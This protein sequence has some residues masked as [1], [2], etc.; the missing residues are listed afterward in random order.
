MVRRESRVAVLLA[1]VVLLSACTS[2]TPSPQGSASGPID[3]RRTTL[4]IG[5][6]QEPQTFDP[7]VNVAA[8]SAYRYYGNI[9]ESLVQYGQDGSIQPMLADSWTVSPDGLTYRFKLKSGVKF[10]DGTPFDATAVKAGLDRLRA[11]KKGGVALFAPVSAI[12]VVDAATVDLVLQQPYAPILAI[13]AGWQGAIFVSPTVAKDHEANGDLGQAYLAKNTAGTGPMMLESWEPNSKIVLVR[14]PNFREPPQADSIQRIVYQYIA[15]PATL[16]QQLEAGDIDIAEQLTPAILQPLKTA[17]GVSVHAD[18]ANGAGFG[19]PIFFNLKKAPFDNVHFRRAVA[20]ALNYERLTTVWN[21]IAEPA[22]GFLPQ[23]FSPWFS[24]KDAVQYKQD[25]TKA[26][27]ELKEAGYGVPI[28]PTIKITLLWQAGNTAQ[29]DMAQ[30][31]KED[32]A[33]IGVDLDIQ[34]KEITVWRDAIWKHTFEMAYLGLPLR[35]SDPDSIASLT[36]ISSEYRDQGFNPGIT[37]K[38]IDDLILQGRSAV[39]T[40]K[41]VPIYNQLQKLV[42][43]QALILF[44]VNTKYAWGARTN[45]TGISWNPNYGPYWRA[46]AI[47]KGP[48]K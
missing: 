42:T 35:Y 47:K 36:L 37:D 33:K 23:T 27:A 11:I 28:S 2:S 5:V 40:D 12:N 10:S 30:L 45:V 7:S 8:V 16:R 24:A 46:G 43:D 6:G 38:T 21:G 44:T 4:T 15:E 14:N 20:Y 19:Q 34:E 22:Q 3:P 26:A 31:M 17:Q 25:L 48:G 39:G 32:L 9:Y 18:I 1:L 13:L 29:R 41:R